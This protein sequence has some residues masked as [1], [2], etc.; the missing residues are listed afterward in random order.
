MAARNARV[1]RV[2]QFS[3]PTWR[4]GGGRRSGKVATFPYPKAGESEFRY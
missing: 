1:S 2:L 3:D 4:L